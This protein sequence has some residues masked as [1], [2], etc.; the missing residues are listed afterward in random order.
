MRT[1]W[2]PAESH[3]KTVTLPPCFTSAAAITHLWKLAITVR[4]KFSTW[5]ADVKLNTWT[6]RSPA[7]TVW[8]QLRL[9]S[10][11]TDYF[12]CG[13]SASRAV[14]SNDVYFCFCS[15]TDVA[16]SCCSERQNKA[17]SAACISTLPPGGA[18]SNNEKRHTNIRMFVCVCELRGP[19]VPPHN[20]LH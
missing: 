16:A 18:H 3:W 6:P 12:Y 15:V 19:S 1:S 17:G 5:K 2:R 14:A 11:Q 10:T 13:T 20:A 7:A 8:R 4:G 9:L